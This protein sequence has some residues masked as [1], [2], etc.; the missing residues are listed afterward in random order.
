MKVKNFEISQLVLEDFCLDGGAMFGS[1]PKNLWNKKITADEQNRIQMCTRILFL[2]NESNKILIDLGCGEKENDKFRKIYNIVK[3]SSQSL[4]QL[5]PDITDIIL[6]HL[7]FDHAGG[8]T[9]KENNNIKLNFPNANI[10]LQKKNYERALNPSIREKASY[11]KDNIDPLRNAKLH[12]CQDKEEIIPG[13]KVFQVNGHTDGMQWIL[14]GD[15]LSEAVAYVSDLIP[16]AH[17][18]PLPY[19]MGYDLCAS[20]T[21]KEKAD[22]LEKAWKYNWTVVFEH[23][24]NTAAGKIAK[25]ENSNYFLSSQVEIKQYAR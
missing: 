15:E 22:F 7:H 16:T 1:V 19:I 3:R 20:T 24:F 25:D 8:I 9:Y 18:V 11:L 23:D 6:T 21:L 14:I 12:L 2:K 13:I 4:Q 5:F 10:Y 17:H